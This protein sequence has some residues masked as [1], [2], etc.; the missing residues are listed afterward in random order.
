MI[1]EQLSD[2]KKFTSADR[3]IRDYIMKYPNLVIN[4]TLEEL[5]Q[6]SFVSQ[7]S[8]I[9]FCKKLGLKGFADFKIQLASE[10]NRFA[11]IDRQIPV[12]IPIP[13]EAD[14]REISRIMYNL[15]KQALDLALRELDYNAIKKAAA[16][17]SRADTVYLFGRGESLILAED[18]HYKLLRIGIRSSLDTSNGFQEVHTGAAR[19]LNEVALVISQYCNSQHINY[20]IDELTSSKIPYILL[21]ASENPWPYHLS[22]AVTIRISNQESRHKIGSFSSRTGFLYTLDCIFGQVFSLN[23]QRNKQLLQESARRK[24][25]RDYFYKKQSAGD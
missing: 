19:P 10:L 7:A 3:Q 21:T 20:V 12:D 25:A 13:P 23:Y 8:V 17:I 18:F 15:S 1:F 2:E 4:F 14:C 16:L 22:A 5:S 6:E 9:R 24:E 11:V